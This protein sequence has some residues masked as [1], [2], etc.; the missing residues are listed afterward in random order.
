[1]QQQKYC[2]VVKHQKLMMSTTLPYSR[3]TLVI[4]TVC[5]FQRRNKTSN[6]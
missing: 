3:G 1:M 2:P 5:Y 6:L 4:P